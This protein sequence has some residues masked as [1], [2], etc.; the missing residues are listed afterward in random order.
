MAD[1]E[2]R[3]R[4]V[5]EF[6]EEGMSGLLQKATGVSQA[7]MG[8]AAAQYL[9][10]QAVS[11]VAG[12]LNNLIQLNVQREAQLRSITNALVAQQAVGATRA[13]QAVADAAL[14]G[15]EYTGQLSAA[16][17]RE[18]SA[19]I[20]Q[21]AEFGDSARDAYMRSASSAG[22]FLQ[23]Q[24]AARTMMRM[25][26]QDAA[27]LPGEVN[28]YATAMQIASSSV[29]QAAAG[30]RYSNVR[31]VM[32]LINNTTAAAINA[33]IDSAQA[34]RDIMRMMS[35]GR[36]Q[37]ALDNRTWTE[38]I[39]PY[40]T[41]ASGQRLDASQFNALRA[42]ERFEV[43]ERTAN[44]LRNIMNSS[45]DSWEAVIGTLSSARDELIQQSTLP[46]YKQIQSRLSQFSSW[47]NQ[48]VET[49]TSVLQGLQRVGEYLFT[50]VSKWLD[51]IG[52]YMFGSISRVSRALDS[53]SRNPALSY[54]IT[55]FMQLASGIQQWLITPT[56]A[57]G[58]ALNVLTLALSIFNPYMFLAAGFLRYL[59]SG[60]SS[61]TTLLTGIATLGAYAVGSLNLFL[62]VIDLLTDAIAGMWDILGAP[63]GAILAIAG[64]VMYGLVAMLLPAL[65]MLG[66]VIIAGVLPVLSVA[67]S[68][69][70]FFVDAIVT[71]VSLIFD[72]INVVAP[73]I[74]SAQ[75]LGQ[76]LKN[77]RDD[78][79]FVAHSIR[80][81]FEEL[82]SMLGIRST[83]A[84]IAEAAGVATTTAAGDGML[85]RMRRLMA[86]RVDAD[87]NINL[88]SPRQR[89]TASTHNDFRFSRFDITQRFAEG[90]D[91]DRIATLFQRDISNAANQRTEG[92][93]GLAFST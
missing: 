58:G 5:T 51:P 88:T 90:F 10:G 44:M 22:T 84:I 62:G 83:A 55:L 47:L 30:T 69:L 12:P 18:I 20:R 93:L 38:V 80:E 42:S 48:G 28:D 87:G 40:A 91:P 73:G 66:T 4:V 33:G 6:S 54:V 3:N 39:A 49:G 24:V 21:Y 78:A 14:A 16:T 75:T 81:A 79:I 8:I 53:V 56:N 17:R 63:L 15:R 64:A 70:M 76:A 25:M 13:V 46:L 7:L 9:V 11:A 19:G 92:G 41:R 2:I 86:G 89:P 45:A 71:F 35:S 61:L 65:E 43:L 32:S 72:W 37:A 59:A 29:I 85:E 31:S 60:S 67:V 57:A 74:S 27:A 50:N 26:V 23:A 1:N 82:K 36:G 77:L 34:G 52:D 68:V